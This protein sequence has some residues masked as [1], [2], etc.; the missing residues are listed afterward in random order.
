MAIVRYVSTTS[1][2]VKCKY[3][4]VFQSGLLPCV[5]LYTL[6][7]IEMLVRDENLHFRVERARGKKS[8]ATIKA[9]RSVLSTVFGALTILLI[10]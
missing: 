9:A 3:G 7:S 5:L 6:Y 4:G 8:S 2:R 10:V 1:Y